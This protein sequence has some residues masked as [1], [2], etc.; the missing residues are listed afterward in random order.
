VSSQPLVSVGSTFYLAAPD[1]T[2]TGMPDRF[3]RTTERKATLAS[4]VPLARIRKPAE[5][6]AAVLFLASAVAACVTDQ[7]ATVGGGKT[8]G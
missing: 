6:A 2:D 5:I 3:T 4:A 1:P 8:A 7:I